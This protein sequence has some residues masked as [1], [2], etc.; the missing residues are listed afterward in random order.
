M[1][2]QIDRMQRDVAGTVD[3]IAAEVFAAIGSGRQIAPFSSR[4]GGLTSADAYGVAAA[5]QAMREAR[6]ERAIGRKIGFTNR[7]IWPEY[8][9]YAP[10]WGYITDRTVTEL[11]AAAVP[12]ANFVE[13]KIEPE[14]VFGLGAAPAPDMN[15]AALMACIDWVARGYEIVQSIY[16]RWKFKPEDSVACN[17][18][19]G[20]LLIG[21]RHAFKPRAAQWRNELAAFEID[22]YC[23][24]VVADRGKGANVL[25][26]PL[27]AL[28][29]LVGLL[30]SD[31]V[32]PS[33]AAG[34]IVS[35]GTLTRALAIKPGEKW[36][37]VLRG[38]PLEGIA[39]AFA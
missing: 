24:G 21:P 38:I 12:L 9:V 7:I 28:H 14:I 11:P 37:T 23:N 15:E 26:S 4:S 32:N 10:N 18:M 13:P 3:A 20:A 8:G 17:A 33:L 19:H 39:I 27:L 2:L 34:E 29:H 36:H 25:D 1:L 22:L 35:T 16:P 6:G 31:P 5:V 30:A